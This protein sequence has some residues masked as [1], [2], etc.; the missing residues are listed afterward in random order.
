[1]DVLM[2][3]RIVDPGAIYRRLNECQSDRI[4]SRCKK[5]P[6]LTTL[7]KMTRAD[8]CKED[9]NKRQS[10][11]PSGSPFH[12]DKHY[13]RTETHCEKTDEIYP[14]KGGGFAEDRV[15]KL[16][17]SQQFGDPKDTKGGK[18]L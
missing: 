11:L 8:D 6:V 18:I 17:V 12:R 13:Q 10:S 4:A 15:I 14:Q 3:R 16:G 2:P 5:N 9:N 1:M 7:Q